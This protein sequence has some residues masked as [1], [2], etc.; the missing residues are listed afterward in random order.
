MVLSFVYFLSLLSRG[1]GFL[2]DKEQ[3][4]EHLR[5][6]EREISQVLDLTQFD[7]TLTQNNRDG[8]IR[9][10]Q[11]ISDSMLSILGRVEISQ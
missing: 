3:V 10:V 7:E 6:A 4:R 8:I 9:S 5:S 1:K 2:M 11:S